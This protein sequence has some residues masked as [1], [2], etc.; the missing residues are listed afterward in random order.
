MIKPHLGIHVATCILSVAA[1]FN[2]STLSESEPLCDSGSDSDD[3]CDNIR[4]EVDVA[5]YRKEQGEEEPSDEEDDGVSDGFYLAEA[6]DIVPH[7]LKKDTV[8]IPKP[9]ITVAFDYPLREQYNFEIRA[10]DEAVGFKKAELAY[11]IAHVYEFIYHSEANSAPDPG[12]AHPR[13]LNRGI[14]DGDFGIWGHDL[15]DLYLT[16][17]FYNPKDD[18]YYLSVS[19]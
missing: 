11:K 8:I 15:E 14:S 1:V 5:A 18:I 4:F 2:P 19:S 16:D 6:K 10:D 13:M 17:M 12:R 9:A 3:D 7:M